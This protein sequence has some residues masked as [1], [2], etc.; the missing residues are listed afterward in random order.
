[1]AAAPKP[2]RKPPLEDPLNEREIFAS[3]IAGVGLLHG[4]LV[5]TFAV[6]RFEEPAGGGPGHMRRLVTARVALTNVAA[7]QL[8]KHLH[9]LLNQ[10]DEDAGRAEPTGVRPRGR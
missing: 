7:G 10:I 2:V 3:E 5:I 1:M 6:P 8:L 9:E 4:N